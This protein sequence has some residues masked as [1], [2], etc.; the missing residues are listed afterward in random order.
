MNIKHV[1]QIYLMNADMGGVQLPY[2]DGKARCERLTLLHP[3]DPR[4]G[5]QREYQE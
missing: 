1:R 4:T 3:I 5:R 2:A